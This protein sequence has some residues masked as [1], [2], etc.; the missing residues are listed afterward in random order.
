M[1]EQML[2][3]NISHL[4]NSENKPS[5][6]KMVVE[7]FTTP[8]VAQLAGKFQDQLPLS[9]KEKPATK[10]AHRKPPSSL[11]LYTHKAEVGQNGDL[12]PSPDASHPARVKVKSS[13]RIEKL[14]ANLA[15]S[16]ASLLPGASP[17]SPGPPPASPHFHSS[18]P[19]ETPVSFDQPPEGTHLQFYNKV[20]TRGSIKRRPPSRR[21]RKSQSEYGDDLDSGLLVSPHEN[22]T[23]CEDEDGV[24]MD[25]SKNTESLSDPS[26][27]IDHHEKQNW[28]ASGEKSPSD[29]GLND[30]ESRETEGGAEEVTLCKEENPHQ[31]HSEEEL[32]ENTKEEKEKSP[33]PDTAK[34]T[35]RRSRKSTLGD[36]E[37]GNASDKE[38][39][40]KGGKLSE[41][42]DMQQIPGTEDNE[43][44]QPTK[45]MEADVSTQV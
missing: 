32:C 27:G 29:P 34:D 33:S 41:N 30:T 39:N 36:R 8:S 38:K 13:P 23:K 9:G 7:K 25:K 11:P 21:F 45:E 20:R 37:D 12:K 2:P 35:K 43:I 24:F 6:N 10:P 22:G 15:F 19:D 31:N 5:E 44:P 42:E 16:P 40:D 3:K 4:R 18:E 28:T 26:D 14:Q 1:G 17:K